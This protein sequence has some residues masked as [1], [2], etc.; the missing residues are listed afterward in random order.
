MQLSQ[1]DVSVDPNTGLPIDTGTTTSYV[2]SSGAPL[3][4]TAPAAAMVQ[5][6]PDPT[7]M[8]AATAAAVTGS[9]D[10]LGNVDVTKLLAS[11]S[12]SYVAVNNA[13]KAG[14]ASPWTSLHPTPGTVTTLPGGGSMVVN[15]DGSTTVTDAQGNVHTVLL[16]GTTIAGAPSL[17]SSLSGSTPLL[18]LGG[19]AL[20]GLMLLKRK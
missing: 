18:L 2:D 19:A 8:N 12:Q 4:S 1:I 14:S 17:L 10:L 16:N 20:L 7:A 5:P 3:P 15:A 11:L 13:V 9:T 6:A